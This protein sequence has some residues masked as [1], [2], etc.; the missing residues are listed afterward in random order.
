LTHYR[1]APGAAWRVLKSFA[2]SAAAGQRARQPLPLGA[3]ML[4]V[5][6]GWINHHI[7]QTDSKTLTTQTVT[8]VT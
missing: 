4:A 6:S 2:V 8:G 7:V 1:T 3:L 5:F